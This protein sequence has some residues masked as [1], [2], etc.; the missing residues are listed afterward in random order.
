[1][2]ATAKARI[3]VLPLLFLFF[4]ACTTLP[5]GLPVENNDTCSSRGNL[6]MPGLQCCDAS[7]LRFYFTGD[8][9]FP[10]AQEL[11]REAQDY[12]LI[13]SFLV[14]DDEKSSR[15]YQ[16]LKEKMEQGVRVYILTDS[17]SGYV[18]GRTAVPRLIELGIPVSEF[19][20][21]RSS[22]FARLPLFLYRDHRKFWLIDGRTVVLG[23]QNIWSKSLD[24]PEEYGNT[25]SMVEFRSATACRELVGSFVREWNAYSTDKLRRESFEI[26]R[27]GEG[28]GC[29]WLVHQDGFGDTVVREMFGRLMDV[30]ESEIWMIQAYAMADRSLLARIRSL[31]AAGVSVNIIFSSAYH[32]LDKFYYATGYRMIDLIDA[33]ARLWEY[34]HPISHLH[35]KGVI[36]DNRWFALGS[37]N[38]NFRS[39]YLS[40]ELNIVFEGADMGQAML[41]NLEQLKRRAVSISREKAAGYRGPRFFFY[42]LLLFFG[43]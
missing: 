41:E 13:D 21:I 11:I 15:I 30:A 39:S 32:I 28:T 38:L 8:A 10:R 20:P 29:I 12:I 23:G 17:S 36:V 3:V 26:E 34:G 25:D 5:P 7:R 27:G 19:N 43:G 33:G 42:H 35:Y 31:T 16:L 6:S 37:A 2:S 14:I 40:K 22:R 18:P 4:L 9:F 1:M 24:S